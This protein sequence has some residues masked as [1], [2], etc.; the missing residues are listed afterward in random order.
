MVLA[1]LVGQML[2]ECLYT[3]HFLICVVGE[4]TQQRLG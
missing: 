1:T 3:V 2:I 4:G